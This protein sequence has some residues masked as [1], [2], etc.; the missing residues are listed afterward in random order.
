MDQQQQLP[1]AAAAATATAVATGTQVESQHSFDAR[2][3]V[4]SFFY[5]FSMDHSFEN[6]KQWDCLDFM[7]EHE[8]TH[9]L[10]ASSWRNW[11]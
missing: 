6:K 10:I 8:D 7:K 4:L 5:E 9:L 1:T 2:W 11:T 3:V